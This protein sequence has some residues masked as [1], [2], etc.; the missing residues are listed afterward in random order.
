M[1]VFAGRFARGVV[2]NDSVDDF[3]MAVV[4]FRQFPVGEVLAVEQCLEAFRWLIEL[5]IS[6]D[7]GTNCKR[8]RGRDD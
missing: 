3:P 1:L 7:A 8:E 6:G 5:L 4:A 2:V